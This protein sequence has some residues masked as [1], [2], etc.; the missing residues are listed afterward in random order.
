MRFT[1]SQ[2]GATRSV[3]GKGTCHGFQSIVGSAT[4]EINGALREP[5]LHTFIFRT[6]LYGPS[7]TT[8]DVK[9]QLT[10]VRALLLYHTTQ[11]NITEDSKHSANIRTNG[12]QNDIFL[13]TKIKR[14][15]SIQLESSQ[16][17]AQLKNIRLKQEPKSGNEAV[18]ARHF[19]YWV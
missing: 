13:Q 4:A 15:N 1:G 12:R 9:N 10:R 3:F 17:N 16:S 11:I 6:S 19:Q 14:T 8:L 18:S 2:L 5:G 7:C